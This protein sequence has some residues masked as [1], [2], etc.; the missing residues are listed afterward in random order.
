MSFLSVLKS[1]KIIL[2]DGAMGTQLEKLGG[3]LSGGGKNNLTHPEIVLKV[4]QEYVQSGAQVLITNTFTMNPIYVSTHNIDVNL[5]AVN[6]AGV[7]LARQAAQ[8]GQYVMGGLGPTGQMLQPF[9]TYSEDDFYQGFK[10]QAEILAASGIDGFI[11]ETMFDVNE[12]LCALRACRDAAD[13][14][15]IVS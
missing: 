6:R 11:I 3:D 2:L 14:P 8:E 15:V 4:H 1:G 12:A 7:E 10:Q 9:G 5:P 13:L